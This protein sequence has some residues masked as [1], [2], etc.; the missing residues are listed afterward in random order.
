[1]AGGQMDREA[2]NV[3]RSVS[4][5]LASQGA[6]AVVVSG[7]W[8]RGDSHGESD[9][10]IYAIGRGPLYRLERYQGFLVS[11]SWTTTRKVLQAF[12]DPSEVGGIIPGWRNAVIIRD[13]NGTAKKLKQAAQEWQWASLGNRTNEWIAEELTGWAEEVHRL[14]GN[15]WLKRKHAAA[16]QR[17]LLAVHMAPLLAVHHRVLYDTENQLWDLVSAKMGAEWKQSQGVALGE[18]NQSFEDTC[19]AAL[20][21]YALTAREVKHLLDERQYPVVAHACE[22]AGYSL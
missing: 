8:V 6:E 4:D 18:G 17:S 12:R 22:I 11:V 9:I 20:R 5:R 3:S 1:M 10:D 14:I 19:T 7:S 2:L 13:P 15:R 21:L 16:V